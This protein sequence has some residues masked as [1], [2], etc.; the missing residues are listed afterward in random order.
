MVERR[1]RYQKND[2]SAC[3]SQNG[4]CNSQNGGMNGNTSS[5]LKRLRKVDFAI[6]DT[7]LY[8]DAYPN[9]K[10]ALEYY[11]KLV[12]ERHELAKKLAEHGSP[13]NVMSNLGDEWDW[14]KSP[15][16]WEY[17]ANV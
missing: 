16:P 12:T 15:W 9:C 3:N 13:M 8:L 7:M 2:C 1:M 6:V 14:I 5:L 11:K 10:A 17:E 4:G